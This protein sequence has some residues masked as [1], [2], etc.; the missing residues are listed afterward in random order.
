M[1]SFFIPSSEGGGD[2][3][4]SLDMLH[5]SYQDPGQVATDQGGSVLGLVILSADDV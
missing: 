5:D 1:G 2:G 3:V 4:H